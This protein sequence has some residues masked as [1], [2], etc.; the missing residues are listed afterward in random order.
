MLE[1]P[2]FR[3]IALV[4]LAALAGG[5]IATWLRQPLFVGYI[6]G[7]IL[8]SPFTPGPYVRDVAT[9][10][11]F[12][13]I[14]VILLMFSIGVELELR[15]VVR[16]GRPAL[17][18]APV[19]A[20]LTIGTAV[21]VGAALRWPLEQAAAVGIVIANSSSM[22]AARLLLERGE[23]HTPH[24]HVVLSTTL[25]ED[26]I[27]VVLIVVL[28]VL[29]LGGAVRP[30]TNPTSGFVIRNVRQRSHGAV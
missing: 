24:G 12:A 27:T 22:V 17:V 7:G 13:Q 20:A 2:F 19:T 1:T 3:D 10:Q 25:M 4:V 29:A 21:A 8:V 15:D 11:Q 23:M 28:P 5:A 16:V 18:G 26:L 14:G 6:I 9:F 30:A